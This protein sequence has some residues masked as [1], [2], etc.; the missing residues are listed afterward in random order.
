MQ[1]ELRVDTE[2]RIDLVYICYDRSIQ[3]ATDEA[4]LPLCGKD[5]N[6]W[7]LLSAP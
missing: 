4:S 7:R 3:T 5:N 1:T 2:K 6:E